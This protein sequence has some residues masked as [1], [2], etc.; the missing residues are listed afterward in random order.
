M[1]YVNWQGTAIN[2]VEVF[3]HRCG[4]ERCGFFPFFK[5]Y[6]PFFLSSSTKG[7][8]GRSQYFRNLTIIKWTPVSNLPV[9]I[10][11]ILT[12]RFQPDLLIKTLTK[13]VNSVDNLLRISTVSTDKNPL[14][15]LVYSSRRVPL[16]L[17]HLVTQILRQLSK[18]VLFWE[19]AAETNPA[20][21]N[22]REMVLLL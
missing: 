10:S 12:L 3:T 11:H 21:S 6:L 20:T 16:Y 22:H 13:N 1:F 7:V 18:T 2:S 14:S 19:L 5:P 8:L 17:D 4:R 9:L 15:V